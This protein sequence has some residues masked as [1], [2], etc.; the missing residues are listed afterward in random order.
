MQLDRRKY[1]TQFDLA[2]NTE[3]KRILVVD[4]EPYNLI[5]LKVILEAAGG[6]MSIVSLVDTA[7]NGIEAVNMVKKAFYDDNY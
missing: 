7:T 5:G 1:R 6:D 4:D 3:Q 2:E